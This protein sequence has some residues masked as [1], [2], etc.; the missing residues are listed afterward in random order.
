MVRADQVAAGNSGITSFDPE[1][2]LSVSYTSEHQKR[3][4]EVDY[5]LMVVG[6]WAENPAGTY[7]TVSTSSRILWQNQSE[8]HRLKYA[9]PL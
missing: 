6:F 7:G 4:R 1:T 9:S 3:S 8:L 2:S 5:L